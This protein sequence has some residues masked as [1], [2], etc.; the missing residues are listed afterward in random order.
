MY[1]DEICITNIINERYYFGVNI[2]LFDNGATT[3]Q[4]HEID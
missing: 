3:T 2:I 4:R 1:F